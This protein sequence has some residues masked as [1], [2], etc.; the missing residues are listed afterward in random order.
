MTKQWSI[1]DDNNDQICGAGGWKKSNSSVND[2]WSMYEWSNIDRPMMTM[3]IK[4]A[5]QEDGDNANKG[6]ETQNDDL[7]LQ[8]WF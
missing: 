6:P 1:Y 4:D 5:G 7:V 3:M 2:P 8:G